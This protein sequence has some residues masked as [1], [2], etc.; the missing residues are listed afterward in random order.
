MKRYIIIGAFLLFCLHVIA[1]SID[2]YKEGVSPQVALINQYGSYP[3]DYSTGLVDISIPLYT[4]QTP[5]LNIPLQLKFHPSGLRADE[6]EG[7]FGI[8][9]AL[10]GGG[11]I[12]RTIKGLPD[13]FSGLAAYTGFNKKVMA[14][15]YRPDFRTLYGATC[16]TGFNVH[17]NIGANSVFTGEGGTYNDTEYDIFTYS[18][19]SGK[20]GKFILTEVDG[21]YKAFTMPYEPIKIKVSRYAGRAH[22]NYFS[23]VDEKGDIYSFGGDKVDYIGGEGYATTW[24]LVKVES[25]NKQDVIEIDYIKPERKTTFWTG[26]LTT[27]DNFDAL[28]S[29]PL[30]DGSLAYRAFGETLFENYLDENYNSITSEYAPFAISSIKAKSGDQIICRVDFEFD[31]SKKYMEE[32]YAYDAEENTLRAVRFHLKDNNKDQMKILD[33]IEID[34]DKVYHFEYYNTQNIPSERYT[35]GRECD[36][37]GYA[38]FGQGAIYTTNGPYIPVRV[39][40]PNG[41]MDRIIDAKLYQTKTGSKRANRDAMQTGM[42][43]EIRYPTGGK[44]YFIYEANENRFGQQCGGLRINKIINMLEDGKE[45]IKYYEYDVNYA[46]YLSPPKDYNKNIKIENQ[47]FAHVEIDDNTQHDWARAFY[48][49]TTYLRSFPHNEF[50]SNTVFYKRVWEYFS[51]PTRAND[52]GK[53][54]YEYSFNN[55]VFSYYKSIKDENDF[56][57]YNDYKHI[58]VSPTDSWKGGKLISKTIYKGKKPLKEYTYKYSDF[59]MATIYDL[60][61]FL[62]GLHQVSH[63][64]AT[65]LLR[66][67]V[68]YAKEQMNE[69]YA[70]RNQ[71]YTSGVEKL[72]KETEITYLDD[73][74]EAVVTKDVTY[75][76]THLLPIEE[77][78]TASDGSIY[79]TKYEY[80]NYYSH[81][82]YTDMVKSNILSPVIEKRNFKD[83][84]FL[85]GERNVYSSKTAISQIQYQTKENP[86]ESRINFSYHDQ[87][88]LPREITKDGTEKVVHIRNAYNQIVAMILN[89]GYID[90]RDALGGQAVV[91][92]ISKSTKVK[93]EDMALLNNLRIKLPQAHISTY[94]YDSL[95][96]IVTYINPSGIKTNYSYSDMKLERIYDEDGN[97]IE[98]YDY[99]YSNK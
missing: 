31:N 23:I 29:A 61:I 34:Y 81:S 47:I 50:R 32:M 87:N 70:Y 48:I 65:L 58:Y 90:I 17:G 95:I 80:P 18:L 20:S 83:N 19:P 75:D 66:Q 86:A 25:A 62:Y 53:I 13:D 16:L 12:S 64:N 71:K 67:K 55:P 21:E 2:S 49:K 84:K 44:T 94:T 14:A 52:E 40:T 42:L 89:S 10:F 73:G 51:E 68:Q 56:V 99:N 88:S 36:W 98:S 43:K 78:I 60:P 79:S 59:H 28:H 96:G 63:T 72:V 15:E 26:N 82:P 6:R 91:D 92:R 11:H 30:I 24:H 3:V 77:K 37:W 27:F 76:S 45:E 7:I 9:W 57:G 97:T 8:R 22:F 54:E 33:K 93:D 39:P 41:G 69:M 4:I 74:N 1:Q 5:S 85:A 35:L 46:E 38:S